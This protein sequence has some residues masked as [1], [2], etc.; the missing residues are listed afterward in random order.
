M[1]RIVGKRNHKELYVLKQ[2][3]SPLCDGV[4]RKNE[5]L[6]KKENAKFQP[7]PDNG[8]HFYNVMDIQTT[9][10]PHKASPLVFNNINVILNRPPTWTDESTVTINQ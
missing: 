8:L 6:R 9:G 3:S 4:K 2:R 1:K 7:S 5:L 10:K